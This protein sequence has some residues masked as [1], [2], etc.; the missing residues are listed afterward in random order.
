MKAQP[1][2]TKTEHVRAILASRYPC[3]AIPRGAL[4]DIAAEVGCT[5]E[6]V[7][8]VAVAQEFDMPGRGS[9][10]AAPARLCIECQEPLGLNA[11]WDYHSSCTPTVIVQCSYCGRDKTVSLALVKKR[12]VGSG[13][14]ARARA[15]MGSSDRWYCDRVC[16]GKHLSV[17]RRRA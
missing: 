15:G 1:T 16:Q 10:A 9:R 8:Q 17:I 3:Q 6:L 13:P 7:R 11:K 12:Y 14:R 2:M 4:T 5:H